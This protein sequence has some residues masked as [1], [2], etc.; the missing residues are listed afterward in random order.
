MAEIPASLKS[1]IKKLVVD[2]LNLKDVDP[3]S[4]LDEPSFFTGENTI[5]LDSI[6]AIE[7]IMAVQ[8]TFGVRLDDQNVARN[9]ITSVNNIAGFI[10]S[11]REKNP[12]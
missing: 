7:L 9:I 8:R 2:T 4:I 6:D 1:E 10:I 12:A 11:E 5:T 3:G